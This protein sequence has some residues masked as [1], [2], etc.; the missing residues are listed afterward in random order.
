M[1]ISIL[2]SD[3]KHSVIPWL[4]Q[5]G[6][7][8][9]MGGHRVSLCHDKND[10]AGGDILFLV[11]C[12]QVITDEERQ[13]YRAVLVLHASDLPKG[14]GWSPHVWA[15]L[16]GASQITVCLIEA[17]NPVDSGPIWLRTQFTLEG[18]E[19]LPEIN[20]RLFSAELALMTRA[21]REFA[22]IVPVDQE[23]EPGPYMQ[24]RTPE[25]SRLDVNKT[26][27]EQFDLL[28]VV[29]NERFPAY[30]DCRGNRYRLHIEKVSNGQ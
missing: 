8:M 24:K 13:K 25:Q 9:E 7:E 16:R 5:W 17:R 21:V 23:G 14:R 11:S 29:D 2:S 6:T 3:P 20:E 15:I 4:R 19:L 26:I 18:H 10:L 28:R 22:S 12:S 27:A 1:N 30:F